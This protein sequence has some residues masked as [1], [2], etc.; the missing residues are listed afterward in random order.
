MD[1]DRRVTAFKVDMLVDSNRRL[2]AFKVDMLVDLDRRIM[3]LKDAPVRPR[4]LLR[5]SDHAYL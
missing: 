3:A 4:S 5:K 1:F 2:R